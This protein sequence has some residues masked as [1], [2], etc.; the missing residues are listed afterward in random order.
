MFVHAGKPSKQ[1]TGSNIKET[2]M[3]KGGKKLRQRKISHWF[4]SGNFCIHGGSNED[5]DFVLDR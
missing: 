3:R 5:E 4:C 2:K 1:N